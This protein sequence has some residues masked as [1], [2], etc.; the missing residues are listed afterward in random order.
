MSLAS[1]SVDVGRQDFREGSLFARSTHRQRAVGP[2]FRDCSSGFGVRQ[3]LFS[4][5]RRKIKR[6]AATSPLVDGP[7]RVEQASPAVGAVEE[8]LEKEASVDSA[9]PACWL[10]VSPNGT[11]CSVSSPALSVPVAAARHRVRTGDS[12]TR[13]R[14]PCRAR[15]GPA[16]PGRVLRPRGHRNRPAPTRQ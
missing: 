2:A 7:D 11:G 13:R 14:A 5:N 12:T 6:A 4:R 16:D 9:W 15:C 3:P 1:D 8:R 10:P